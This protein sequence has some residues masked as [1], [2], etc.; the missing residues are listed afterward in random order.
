MHWRFP[1]AFNTNLPVIGANILR[2]A[3]TVSR[4]SGGRISIEIHEP[5]AIVPAFGVT[6]AV[7]EHRVPAGYTWLGYDQGHSPASALISAVPFGM[8]P[9]E[10]IAWWYSA[11]GRQLGE[12]LYHKQGLQPVLC[13]LISPETAGWFRSPLQSLDDLK[14]LKIRF[15][16]LGGKVLQKLGGAVTILPGGE[17]FPALEKGVIDATEYSLPVIDRQLG[18]HRLAGYNYFPGWHQ[19][20]TAFHLV[21]DLELWQSLKPQNR[22]WIQTTCIAEVTQS[23]AEAEALQGEVLRDFSQTGIVTSQLSDELL[24]E[25]RRATA[26]VL[27]E[28]AVRNAD[29]AKIYRHQKAFRADYKEWRRLAYLKF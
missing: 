29:F 19:P 3:Q 12:E 26:Q 11:G 5:G 17:I 16:G 13:G 23:L 20:A 9:L 14:G 28:E 15:A 8:V 6:Q 2:F 10:F 27:D 1:V 24:Q 18:L 21:I 25:L 7:R 22:Q 4:V